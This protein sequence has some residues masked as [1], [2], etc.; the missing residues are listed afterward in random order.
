MVVRTGRVRVGAGGPRP[1]PTSTCPALG[2]S[3]AW[4]GPSSGARKRGDRR[5]SATP[6]AATTNSG[7]TAGSQ[8]GLGAP[9]G[10]TTTLQSPEHRS[11]ALPVSRERGTPGRRGPRP[12]AGDQL[13]LV[14]WRLL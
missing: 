6:P 10:C 11:A 9:V 3:D 14:T 5:G 1:S 7:T 4:T 12:R 8:T 13:G 2:G